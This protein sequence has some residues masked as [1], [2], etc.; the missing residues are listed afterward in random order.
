M[1]PE[2]LELD[3]A[4][5][6]HCLWL[7]QLHLSGQVSDPL[8][9]EPLDQEDPANESVA[10]AHEDFDKGK[11]LLFEK[12]RQSFADAMMQAASV[13]I[14]LLDFELAGK[15]PDDG[16]E[17]S[18][19]NRVEDGKEIDWTKFY[20]RIVPYDDSYARVLRRKKLMGKQLEKG[21]EAISHQ[22]KQR[23][24]HSSAFCHYPIYGLRVADQSGKVLF[25]T[26]LCYVCGNYFIVYPDD[27][28]TGTW[29]D[30]NSEKLEAFLKKEM[31][32]P[33]REL[34][35]FQAKH[36]PKKK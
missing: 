6:A 33:Q 31:P 12:F 22:L 2:V 16:R 32:I 35:R 29:V 19:D 28:R 27:F 15:I 24:K 9:G 3:H 36:G 5:F 26:S 20:L 7:C 23:D 18:A 34:D 4:Y 11:E 8:A 21:R 10:K 30:L 17:L 14:F 1:A 25:Q 13:E